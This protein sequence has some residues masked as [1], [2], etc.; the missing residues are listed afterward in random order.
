MQ[1]YSSPGTRKSCTGVCVSMVPVNVPFHS[2]YCK[3]SEVSGRS[4]GDTWDADR[5]GR[6]AVVSRYRNVR[7]HFGPMPGSFWSAVG[8]PGFHRGKA[9]R[10]GT[11]ESEPRPHYQ[12]VAD[13]LYYRLTRKRLY[14]RLPT[15]GDIARAYRIPVFTAQFVLRAVRTRLRAPGRLATAGTLALSGTAWQRMA[16]D[17]RTRIRCGHMT[18]RLPARAE[19]AAEYGVSIDTASKATRHLAEEGLLRVLG[20]QGTHVCSPLAGPKGGS[21]G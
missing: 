15:T 21:H 7:P 10:S 13:D 3:E 6:E 18:G 4:S 14:G 19:L 2:R 20:R 9:A 1:Q 16:D 5:G 8:P 11:L 12:E 17:L